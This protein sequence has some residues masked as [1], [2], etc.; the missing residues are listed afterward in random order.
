MAAAWTEA[1]P[2]LSGDR[3]PA[4]AGGAELLEVFSWDTEALTVSV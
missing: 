4:R 2:V 1:V 3:S